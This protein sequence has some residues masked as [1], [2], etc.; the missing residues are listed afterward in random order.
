MSRFATESLIFAVMKLGLTKI[1]SEQE[2][3]T[4]A[5]IFSCLFLADF[6]SYWFQVYSSYLLDQESHHTSNKIIKS[7][8]LALKRPMI[9]F[10]MNYLAELYTFS[11]YMRFFP[12]E[13]QSVIKHER[14]SLMMQVALAGAI[15][16][17]FHNVLHLWVSSLRIVALDVRI[18]NKKD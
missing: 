14:F 1:E 17:I 12:H 4:F 18:K 2:R 5:F 3:M 9:G 6:V 15:L 13:F 16:K 7:I 8:L 11:Y 10:A